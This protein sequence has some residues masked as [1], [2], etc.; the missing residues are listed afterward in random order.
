MKHIAKF[1]FGLLIFVPMVAFAKQ[2]VNMYYFYSDTCPHCKE[3]S[4]E[5]EKIAKDTDG[6]A[7]YK[8]EVSKSSKNRLLFMTIGAKLDIQTGAVPFVL[9]GDKNFVG[10]GGDST[11]ELWLERLADCQDR[12][13]DDKCKDTM[14]TLEQ[15]DSAESSVITSGDVEQKVDNQKVQA[16]QKAESAEKLSQGLRANGLPDKINV[17]LI[18]EAKFAHFSLPLITVVFGALD[19]FNPCAMWTL[20]FLIGF[21]L[22]MKDKKRMWMLGSAFI[23]TSAVIYYLFMA[24][25][26]NVILLLGFVIWIRILIGGV[27]IGAGVFNLREYIQNKGVVCEVTNDDQ[28][29]KTIKKMQNVVET[30]SFWL[31]LVG[32]VGL[33]IGVNLIELVCSAGLPAIYTQILTLNELPVW[34]YY[35]Y[36]A[37]YVLVFMLDDLMIFVV[38][39]TTLKLTGMTT[40]YVRL[41]HLI[42]GVVMLIIGLLLIFRPE[43]LTF[44]G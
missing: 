9:I 21:L 24:A 20:I 13:D 38:A 10:Y 23:F 40:K 28:K 5:L 25:W 3:A 36:I 39:M 4:P 33:A 30:K 1:L 12:A 19:G 11:K 17:P 34:Q 37:L 15:K 27:A 35:G 32:I 22:N 18:G 7:L 6:V 16:E 44:A 29:S 42:G 14:A 2:D 8:F 26:L 43:L 41:S 31:A